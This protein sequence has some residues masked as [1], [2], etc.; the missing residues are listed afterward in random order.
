[1]KVDQC[2]ATHPNENGGPDYVCERKK[3]HSGKHDSPVGPMWTDG[4]AE[5]VRQ[6]IAAKTK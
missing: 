4:G 3:G 2:G 6:E 1:M 5:R